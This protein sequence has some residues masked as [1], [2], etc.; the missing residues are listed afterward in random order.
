MSRNIVKNSNLL[1]FM[2]A[3]SNDY[4]RAIIHN[5]QPSLIKCY[6]EISMNLLD[7]SFPAD[8]KLKKNVK[9][10]ERLLKKLA[11]PKLKTASKRSLLRKFGGKFNKLFLPAVIAL[12][13]L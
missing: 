4:T 10:Y 3:A 2:Q 11:S 8:Q 1:K 12:L 9:K 13:K 5:A 7:N 6:V